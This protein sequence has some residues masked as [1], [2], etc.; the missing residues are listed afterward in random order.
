MA[1]DP[2]GQQSAPDALAAPLLERLFVGDEQPS[3]PRV[4][5]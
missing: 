2:A 3:E 1:V 5:E 4:V